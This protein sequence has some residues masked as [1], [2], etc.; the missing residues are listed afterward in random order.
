MQAYQQR[1]AEARAELSLVETTESD[2]R[3]VVQWPSRR[4]ELVRIIALCERA[5]QPPAPA[6]G[7]RKAPAV[8]HEPPELPRADSIEE[9][10]LRRPR[11][12]RPKS[13]Q[14]GTRTRSPARGQLATRD[15]VPSDPP[16][17]EPAPGSDLPPETGGFPEDRPEPEKN[18]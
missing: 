16:T 6:K 9:L 8:P 4:P 15:T 18:S 1:L 11:A 14:Q 3:V 10:F 17:S 2:P 7:K 12:P 13:L 5:L